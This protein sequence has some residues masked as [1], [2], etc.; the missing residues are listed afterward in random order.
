MFGVEFYINNKFKGY[1]KKD[2]WANKTTEDVNQAFLTSN[3]DELKDKVRHIIDKTDFDDA[4]FEYKIVQ[5]EL[6]KVK[7]Y[8]PRSISYF[9]SDFDVND[10]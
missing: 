4:C 7:E 2:D 5:F 6:K 3:F 8:I 9:N 1:L 10:L